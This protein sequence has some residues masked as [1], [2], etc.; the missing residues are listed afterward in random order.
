[1]FIKILTEPLS[2]PVL[3]RSKRVPK[4]TA[5]NAAKNICEECNKQQTAG[6]Y[7]MSKIIKKR[8]KKVLVEWLPC[9]TCKRIWKPT[10]E[11]LENYGH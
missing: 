1:M 7:P 8:G 4:A 6:S 5:K 3:K 11:P 10:W 2:I 9:G